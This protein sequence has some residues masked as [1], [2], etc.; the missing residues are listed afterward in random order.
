VV[1]RRLRGAHGEKIFPAKTQEHF[2]TNWG[3]H[4]AEPEYVGFRKRPSI[5]AVWRLPRLTRAV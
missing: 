4:A 5:G 3:P 2:K 1:L